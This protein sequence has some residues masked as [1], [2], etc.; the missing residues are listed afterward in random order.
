[1]RVRG[2]AGRFA[3]FTYIQPILTRI[4]GFSEAAVSPI[5]LVFGAGLSIG[6]IAGGRL[7]DRGL[8]PAL[9]GTLAGLAVVLLALAPAFLFK[10]P[11]LMLVGLLG[12]SALATV[13]P[14]PLPLLEK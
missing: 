1:M 4:T 6:N 11:A 7:A 13:P 8:T 9:I 12:A 14:L 10:A 5:L 2:C 3:V